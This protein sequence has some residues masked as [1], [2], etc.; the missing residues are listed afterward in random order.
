[1][2]VLM[3]KKDTSNIVIII[4]HVSLL[5]AAQYKYYMKY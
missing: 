1:M 4:L 5:K 3:H 2:V